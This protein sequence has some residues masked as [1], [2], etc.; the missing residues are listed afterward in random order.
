MIREMSGMLHRAV[1]LASRLVTALADPTG[2][3]DA[4]IGLDRQMIA[5]SA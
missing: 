1:S 3:S 5:L 4:G 2:R